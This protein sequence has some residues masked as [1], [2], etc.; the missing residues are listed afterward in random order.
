MSFVIQE[1]FLCHHLLF[2]HMS[3]PRVNRQDRVTKVR[4]SFS[5]N[6]I[7]ATVHPV[8][9]FYPLFPLPVHSPQHMSIVLLHLAYSLF[10]EYTGSAVFCFRN[11]I[12]VSL[13]QAHLVTFI[14]FIR[15]IEMKHLHCK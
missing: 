7:K 12:S 15:K 14:H 9:L 3:V 4:I 5:A 10:V 11:M 8:S 2:P 1:V 6:R 13:S